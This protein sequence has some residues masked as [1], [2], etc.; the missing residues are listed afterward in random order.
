MIKILK[1]DITKITDVQ[2]IV[3]AANE[4]L[5]GADG[6]SREWNPNDSVS[7]YFYRRVWLSSGSGSKSSRSYGEPVSGRSSR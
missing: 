4:S 7:F 3:N 2:A 1:G 5:P 6:G